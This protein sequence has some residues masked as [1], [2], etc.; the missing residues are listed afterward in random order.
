ML[1][2]II[3]DHD[4]ILSKKIIKTKFNITAKICIC[5]YNSYS[6]NFRFTKLKSYLR[7]RPF[8]TGTLSR[9]GTPWYNK[10]RKS[11]NFLLSIKKVPINLHKNVERH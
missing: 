3:F 1:F 11:D 10:K 5:S 4:T 8:F 6:Y 9:A 2:R 7:R